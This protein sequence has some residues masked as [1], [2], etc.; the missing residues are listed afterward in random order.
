MRALIVLALLS[1]I[2]GCK[3]LPGEP[4]VPFRELHR[5]GGG[6]QLI[7]GV[8]IARASDELAKLWR[9]VEWGVTPEPVPPKVDFATELVVAYFWG[10]KG[11]GGYSVE[12]TR[13][14]LQSSG[15]VVSIRAQ[16]PGR[17]CYVT[18]APTGPVVAI[19][20]RFTGE[21]VEVEVDQH[22]HDCE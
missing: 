18:M 13:V 22:V 3:G 20:A 8:R 2:T 6:N 10:G 17:H 5:S 16:S 14:Q 19:A 7:Q 11:T 4:A 21:S 15:L 12:A 9:D 1:V